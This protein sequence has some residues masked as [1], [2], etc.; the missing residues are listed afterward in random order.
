MEPPIRYPILLL[1]NFL[2]GFYFLDPARGLGRRG[3]DLAVPFWGP[4]NKDYS[5]LGS[6]LGYPYFAK[7]PF[8]GLGLAGQRAFRG[9]RI[10]R[11]KEV[12]LREL[13]SRE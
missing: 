5:T 7:L 8:R 11:V 6:M 4:H 10:V 9:V 13:S 12:R 1:G 3:E 2:R